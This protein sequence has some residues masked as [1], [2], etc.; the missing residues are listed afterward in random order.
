[1]EGMGFPQAIAVDQATNI[2]N[3]VQAFRA[4]RKPT[5]NTDYFCMS[6][7]C[8]S[9]SDNDASNWM[10]GISDTTPLHMLSIP[11]THNSGATTAGPAGDLI[12]G[13]T[14]CQVMSIEE[15]LKHGVRAFDIRSR[16]IGNIFAIHHGAVFQG[17]FFGDVLSAMSSFLDSYPGETIIIRLKEALMKSTCTRSFQD[18][19]NWYI[20]NYEK[21]V[22]VGSEDAAVSYTLGDARG[23]ILIDYY[24]LMPSNI[25]D[26]WDIK[27]CAE[28][29]DKSSSI[30]SH[31]QD[32]TGNL[33]DD[34]LYVNFASGTGGKHAY[35]DREHC[36]LFTDGIAFVQNHVLGNILSGLSHNYG[37]ARVGV[38]FS[39]FPGPLLISRII[40]LNQSS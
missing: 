19:L 37:T 6:S 18:T 21:L 11:G 24:D 40:E 35:D 1:M 34:K 12:E 7:E 30:I 14:V 4:S 23:K 29:Q 8:T 2:I 32:A 33:N 28:N 27:S 3:G 20:N 9:E 31:I 10:E 15:Q 26:E 25:Q 16:H 38:V 13:L 36:S 22:R 39:D 17:Q 5:I